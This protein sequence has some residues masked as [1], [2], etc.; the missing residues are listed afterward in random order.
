PWDAW[1]SRY[2]ADGGTKTNAYN[3]YYKNQLNELLNGNYGRLN[4]T[5]GKREIAEIWLDGATGTTVKQTYDLDGFI[6]I[7]RTL[8]PNCVV[9]MDSKW[10]SSY[11]GTAANFPLDAMW[12]GNEE[13]KIADP[14]WNTIDV[15]KTSTNQGRVANGPYFCVSEADVSIRPGWFYHSAEDN[16]VKGLQDLT[17][18]YYNT[19][20][21][22][23][24]LLLNVPPNRAGV[25]HANDSAALMKL[26]SQISSSFATNLITSS[27]TATAS[28]TRDT[29][30]EASKA[31]DSSND[32]YWTMADG[33][34]TGNIVIDFGKTLEIN[35]VKI[36]E[37]MPLG[38]RISGFTVELYVNST[39][40][41]FGTG[42]TIG[43]QRIVKGSAMK[44][45][46]LRLSITSSQAVPLISNIAAYFAATETLPTGLNYTTADFFQ[47]IEPKSLWTL[48]FKVASFPTNK[49]PSISEMRFFNHVNGI[50][51]E[52]SLTEVTATASS[53]ASSGSCTPDKTLDGKAGTIWEPEWSPKVSMPVTVNY[54]FGKLVNC[55]MIA[56]TPRQDAL[57]NIVK[58]FSL[59]TASTAKTSTNK[60]S[61]FTSTLSSG[62]F[63]DATFLAQN[64]AIATNNW[65]V[66]QNYGT[67]GV[68][69]AIQSSTKDA[70]TQFGV[71]GGWFRLVGTKGPT[72]GIMDIYIDGTKKTTID[73]Y[74][75]TASTDQVLY[76]LDGL[77]AAVHLVKVVV[78]NTKNAS[79]TGT[80]ITLQRMYQMS[81]DVKGIF[82][83]SNAQLNVR[84]DAATVTV[85][86]TRSGSAETA[87]TVDIATSPGT[88]VHG[89]TYNNLSS[90]L[91]FA[92][93]E[94]EKTFTVTLLNNEFTE[95]KTFYVGLSNPTNSHLVGETNKTMIVVSPAYYRSKASGNWETPATWEVSTDNI[96]F[97]TAT[98]APNAS[99][100]RISI[101]NGH[102]VTIGAN[103]TATGLVINPGG[104]LTL[105]NTFTLNSSSLKIESNATGTGTF[106]DKN[107]N[108]ELTVSGSASVQQ[109]LTGVTTKGSGR[110]WWYVSSPVSGAL[111]GVFTPSGANNLGYFNE[112]LATPAYVQIT[113]D[114][115]PLEVGRGYLAQLKSNSTY[116]YT[117][118]LNTGTITLTPTRTGTTASA[119][120]FNLIGNPY[121]SYLNW[122]SADIT[123][124][125]LRPTIWFRTL[126]KNSANGTMVFDTYDGI[127]GT[128]NGATGVVSEYIPP[129][130]GFWVK[131]AT[132][133]K[134]ASL[135]FKNTARSHQNV[136]TNL[137]KAPSL[138]NDEFQILRLKVKA[139]IT[140]DETI[141]VGNAGA[142]DDYD[143]FDSE[144]ISNDDPSVPE[145]Y[146]VASGRELVINHLNS[147]T[148]DKTLALGFRPGQAGTFT[149]EAT[150]LDNINTRVILLDKLKNTEQELTA[151]TSYSFTSDSIATSDRFA[152]S[153]LPNVANG[154][155][156]SEDNGKLNV[157]CT[158]D[159]RIQLIYHGQLNEKNA[160][161]VYNI[162]GQKLSTQKLVK[163]ETELAGT[164]QPGVYMI[165]L[166]DG[167][168]TITRKL[169]IR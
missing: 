98:A 114:V 106:V 83:M 60:E 35:N 155:D 76:E 119:R 157:Y 34:T 29:G 39:W 22:G 164:Y 133:N 85:R 82:Q 44:A 71:T 89:M 1:D 77:T 5:T 92:I 54:N 59:L 169:I 125:N 15:T 102:E 37:Y 153:F 18:I 36:Q 109:Y 50:A 31:I 135:V 139:D 3:T 105:N 23:I 149:L 134:A 6:S 42:Q 32:T 151:G 38:Q 56:Y 33:T 121:P 28:A 64:S 96:T 143:D 101:L 13:G 40:V 152:I 48:R 81:S 136:S 78:T 91:S 99:A 111:S 65:S 24:P 2:G 73:N 8:Q 118:T 154:L 14:A 30:Y 124:T 11:T 46:K 41:T 167:S 9:W 120:G 63:S 19:V 25:F 115:T 131:V 10:Q 126:F 66:V 132:D 104:K 159:K 161:S 95:D 51:Q 165:R 57:G 21:M 103:A 158:P 156:C 110:Q 61:E 166:T 20:G 113:D 138:K 69:V 49:W 79:A 68:G 163:A 4:T 55:T 7:V 26:G 62:S 47:T 75:A 88:G 117:G 17:N 53:S 58:T 142:T 107:E 160:V 16:G 108:G 123:K 130:Q 72:Q 93:G 150:Q 127:T 52:I 84:K 122:K 112:T 144:K 70:W 162:A 45:T 90:T 80:Q 67:S 168:R 43:H 141:V 140:G 100:T 12:V 147:I 145:I 27:M 97:A 94:K 146:T 74:A 87:A 116:N 148:T 137:I 129:M 128:G 86:V